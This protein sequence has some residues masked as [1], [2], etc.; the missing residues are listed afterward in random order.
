MLP[1]PTGAGVCAIVVSPGGRGM[2]PGYEGII[3]SGS[4]LVIVW[5]C[6]AIVKLFF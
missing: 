1:V 4:M 6:I 5:A 3:I 2:K